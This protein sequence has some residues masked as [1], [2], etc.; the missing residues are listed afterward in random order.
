MKRFL[1]FA[2]LA[3][4]L[5]VSGFSQNW[6]PV[7][8]GKTQYFIGPEVNGNDSIIWAFK[9]SFSHMQ[10]LDSVFSFNPIVRYND[11]F[12]PFWDVCDGDSIYVQ[13]NPVHD[14]RFNQP[15]IAGVSMT[16]ISTGGFQFEL[17]SGSQLWLYPSYPI[18]VKWPF[19]SSTTDS[20]WVASRSQLNLFG[21]LD[22][23]AEISVSNGH[24]YLISQ[25]HGLVDWFF[26][27]PIKEEDGTTAIEKG[28]VFG[29]PEMGLG[30]TVP[31]F[32]ELTN[33]D[34][35]DK[36]VIN[37]WEVD[38][39][40]N[41]DHYDFHTVTAV[42][43]SSNLAQY[44]TVMERTEYGIQQPAVVDMLEFSRTPLFDLLPGEAI[45][46][47]N[48]SSG[49]GPTNGNYHA[50]FKKLADHDGRIARL[51][52]GIFFIDS[53][54][55]FGAASSFDFEEF[56][57]TETYAEGLGEIY[58]QHGFTS[59]Y[60]YFHNEKLRDLICY[61]KVGE[62]R[63]GPCDS[64][65]QYVSITE[66]VSLPTFTLYP[67]P[68]NQSVVLEL[69]REWGESYTYTLTD[70]MGSKL[71]Q[72]R[73]EDTYLN[74]PTHAFPNGIYFMSV[75]DEHGHKAVCRFFIAH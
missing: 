32:M 45:I 43:Q 9:T 38:I 71:W 51:H 11:P 23:V 5:H 25:S 74:I 70:L 44:Q 37:D 29:I 67:N 35:G 50:Y 34:V 8:A 40:Y 28:I 65:F 49:T 57:R 6:N 55:G 52:R 18:G 42:S 63:H 15:N 68:A 73:S 22:S 59:I 16:A 54:F 13:F 10:G 31:G 14:L 7:L 36:F 46:D 26:H 1:A 41:H 64:Q 19:Q 21:V 20:A 58:I 47:S 17:K 66:G 75:E 24:S 12:P 33:L 56:S 53:C 3:L 2:F 4:A 62:P 27:D 60:P 72:I 69:E 48:P 61:Q 39:F 30:R